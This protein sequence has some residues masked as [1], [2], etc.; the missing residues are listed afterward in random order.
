MNLKKYKC[1]DRKQ[2]DAIH[3]CNFCVCACITKNNLNEVKRCQEDFYQYAEFFQGAYFIDIT[4]NIIY[5]FYAEWKNGRK[6]SSME[7]SYKKI[8]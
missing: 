8:L 1:F 6:I 3:A 5:L 2:R 4:I 7:E